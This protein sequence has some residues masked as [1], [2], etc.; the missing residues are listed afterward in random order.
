MQVITAVS[1]TINI[2]SSTL[3]SDGRTVPI[4]GVGNTA[5]KADVVLVK[6]PT[7]A[8]LLGETEVYFVDGYANFTDMRFSK[9][10]D[11][12]LKVRKIRNS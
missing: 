2:R 5:W 10:G 9:P 6:G 3:T 7:S 12:E 8:D 11:Y 4:L 1:G